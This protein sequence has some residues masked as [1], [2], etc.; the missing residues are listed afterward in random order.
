LKGGEV[1]GVGRGKRGGEGLAGGEGMLGGG[2]QRSKV[3]AQGGRG[4]EAGKVW[5]W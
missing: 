3:S 2:G 4:A 5:I 1:E